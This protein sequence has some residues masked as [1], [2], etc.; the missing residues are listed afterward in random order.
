[1]ATIC[2]CGHKE[3]QHNPKT[4]ECW[5]GISTNFCECKKYIPKV[6]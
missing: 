4:K 3:W 1:M 2:I 5:H 6:D